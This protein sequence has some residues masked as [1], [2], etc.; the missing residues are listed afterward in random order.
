MERD[1]SKIADGFNDFFSE[2]GW[3]TAALIPPTPQNFKQYLRNPIEN[4]MYLEPVSVETVEN[5]ASSLK[6]K[7]SSGHDELSTKIM[8]KSIN[9]VRVPLT[10]FIN[11][12]LATGVFPDQLKIAKV[13]PVYKASDPTLLNTYRLFRAKHSTIHPIL[14]CINHCAE[15][16]NLDKKNLNSSYIL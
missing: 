3:K 5:T 13:V 7:L 4:S 6:T 15:Y 14:H 12:S 16:H 2:I 10:H 11:R 8:K 9:H 1:I